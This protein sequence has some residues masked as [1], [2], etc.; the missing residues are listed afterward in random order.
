MRSGRT[1]HSRPNSTATTGRERYRH[2]VDDLFESG[3]A[4]V[5]FGEGDRQQEAEEELHTGL[6]D[7]EFLEQFAD[8]ASQLLVPGHGLPPT[9]PCET[10]RFSVAYPQARATRIVP[11]R[12]VEIMTDVQPA[13]PLRVHREMHGDAVVVHISGEVDLITAPVVDA[14][15]AE[16][17]ETVGSSALV[18]VD[19]TGVTFLASVGLSLLVEHDRRCSR[20]GTPLR[21]VATNRAILRAIAVT[22]LDKELAVTSTLA[23]ALATA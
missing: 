6:C 7:P 5:V 14:Q 22:G 9:A 16:A 20:A 18:V 11:R 15:L 19:M 12:R 17:E 21:V 4:C 23:E 13:E 1:N 10:V 2:E 3:R 8:V